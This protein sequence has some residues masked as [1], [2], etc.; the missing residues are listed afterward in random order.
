MRALAR[1]WLLTA[2]A[3]LLFAFAAH[4]SGPAGSIIDLGE[5]PH[6]IQGVPVVYPTVCTPAAP[7]ARFMRN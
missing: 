6:Y 1:W 7:F 5:G 3:M 4:M 2:A